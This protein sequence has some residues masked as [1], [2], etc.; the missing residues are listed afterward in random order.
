MKDKNYLISNGINIEKSLELFGDMATYDET[1]KDFLDVIDEKVATLNKYKEE[2]NMSNY[3]I[4]VHALKTDARYLGMEELGE[5]AYSLEMASKA[6]DVMF[7][8]DNHSKL[9]ELVTKYV[10]IAKGYLLGIEPTSAPVQNVNIPKDKAILIVD[11]SNL[12]ANYVKKIFDDEYEV[13]IA[14]DGAQAIKLVEEDANKKIKCLLLDLNMPNVDGFEVLEHF[15]NNNLFVKV[16]VSIITGNDTKEGVDRAFTYPI[17][18]LLT[19]PFNERDVKKI[20]E[21]TIGFN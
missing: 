5:C 6:N 3:A 19:K 8:M 16:P 10:N 14:N 11:D 2:S 20:V 15:K 21:K 7:V 13:L 4:D 17:V 18:D 9:L 1:L 12:V